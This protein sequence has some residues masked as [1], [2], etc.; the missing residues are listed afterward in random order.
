MTFAWLSGIGNSV[1]GK[2]V[3]SPQ[4]GTATGANVPS[5]ALL[6]V[7]VTSLTAETFT[8]TDGAGTTYTQDAAQTASS[9][10]T[11]VFRG[12]SAAA[13]ANWA[14]TVSWSTGT[15][16]MES[17]GVGYTFTGSGVSLDV[18]A[19]GH[20]S[21]TAPST[22]N[23]TVTSQAAELLFGSVGVNGPSG[24]TYT[25]A[26]SWTT[27]NSGGTTGGSATSNVTIHQAHDIVSAASAYDYKPTLGTSRAWGDVLVTYFETTAAAT[28]TPAPLVVPQ[29]AVMQAANW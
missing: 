1:G 12:I 2:S 19:S 22:G 15:I 10:F 20:G 23:T 4:S 16:T 9:P 25:E 7:S 17:S 26:S 28:S 21:S 6:L 29:A 27:A 8:V 14:L 11:Y 18:T 3:T 5:G 13:Q 24:D